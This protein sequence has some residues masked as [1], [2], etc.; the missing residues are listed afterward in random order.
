MQ[1]GC[2]PCY[3]EKRWSLAC[4]KHDMRSAKAFCKQIQDSDRP[5]FIFTLASKEGSGLPKGGQALVS[6]A[7]VIKPFTFKTMQDYA[8]F[9][10]RQS[11]AIKLSRLTRQPAD[12]SYKGWQFGDC[13]AN[14]R[15]ELGRPNRKHSHSKNSEWDSD[16]KSEGLILYSD[17]FLIWEEPKIIS[18]ETIRQDRW[19]RN[20]S[21]D[22]I[23]QHLKSL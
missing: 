14:Y 8:S 12:D 13:H 18:C 11:Q 15:G 17:H 22:N 21:P 2:G 23:G 16:I 1:D 5:Y 3:L 20:I 9:I 4:C 19:G 6:V 10:S 7:R